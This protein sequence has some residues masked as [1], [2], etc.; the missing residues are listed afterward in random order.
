M[1]GIGHRKVLWGGGGAKETLS[2]SSPSRGGGLSAYWRIIDIWTE[3]NKGKPLPQSRGGG[4]NDLEVKTM[5]DELRT[6]SNRSSFDAVVLNYNIWI[7]P[8]NS[9]IESR[10]HD[11][12]RLARDIAG[13]K[14][15][16]LV[17]Y[18]SSRQTQTFEN[19]RGIYET[20]QMLRDFSAANNKFM[21]HVTLVLEFGNLTNQIL[22]S[23]ARSLGMNVSDPRIV[24]SQPEW[25]LNDNITTLFRRFRVCAGDGCLHMPMVC[26]EYVHESSDCLKNI[27]SH[28]DT[29]W[30]T[31][32][33]GARFSAGVTCLLGCAFNNCT[34]ETKSA[35]TIARCERNCN[36][37]FMTL[38]PIR[39]EW[40]NICLGLARVNF[41]KQELSGHKT[42]S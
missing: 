42:N 20:N 25:E 26:A 2:V 19:W 8:V 29:H 40:L 1:D 15:V 7:L 3:A 35:E 30:C 37:Q 36:E 33:I 18:P 28:D 12:I 34:G 24:S 4:W 39:H 22:W 41:F 13:A 32:L 17:T 38:T 5:R 23:N 31:E 14:A 27:I 16:I 6:H 10:Y 11:A 21:N 9:S